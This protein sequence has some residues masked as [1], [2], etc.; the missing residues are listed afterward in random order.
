MMEKFKHYFNSMGM[1][2]NEKKCE[3]I[4][5]RSKRKEFTLTLPGGQEEVE[6]VKL[7]G[8]WIDN[9]YKFETH[10]QKVCQKLRHKLANISRVRPY[11]S[12]TRAKIITDSLVVS[13]ITYMAVL[14]LR[15]PSN[16]K[17]IQKL[18][19]SAARIVLEAEPKTHVVDMLRELYWLNCENIYEYQLVC[20]MRRLRNGW[21]KAPVTWK[22]IFHDYALYFRVRTQHLRVC[23]RK[24]TS[25][26]RNSFAYRAVTSFNSYELNSRWFAT[27]DDFRR[28]VKFK[29]FKT[30]PNGNL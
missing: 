27:E 30:K 15:L 21:M 9:N 29:I 13:T 4:V 8:L 28:E 20:V 5:F 16:Q 17:K 6:T 1:C 12:Q 10:T 19:N 2:L 25:H 26:G 22:E 24:I 18:L 11:L 14:Y 7:L 23:W 3:L